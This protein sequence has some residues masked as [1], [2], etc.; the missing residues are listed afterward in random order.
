MCSVDLLSPNEN[1][2]PLSV[3]KTVALTASQKPHARVSLSL[4]DF[5]AQ[6][7]L[8]EPAR[9]ASVFSVWGILGHSTDTPVDFGAKTA[10]SPRARRIRRLRDFMVS[11][12]RTGEFIVLNFR[13]NFEMGL[14]VQNYGE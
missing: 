7:Q 9:A 4:V 10:A 12:A 14:S 13:S 6:R 11:I 8:P 5:K 2:A 3:R 1:A